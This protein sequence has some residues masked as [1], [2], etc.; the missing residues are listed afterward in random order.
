MRKQYTQS[1]ISHLLEQTISN[2][3]MTRFFK[4][5]KFLY[6]WENNTP[7]VRYH[8]CWINNNIQYHRILNLLSLY[9]HE[10]TIHREY[11]ITFAI[12]NFKMMA[13][14]FTRFLSLWSQ[15][16]KTINQD[17]DI[18]NNIQ[19]QDD[20]IFKSFKSLSAWENNTPIVR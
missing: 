14:V 5:F 6:T 10:E 1:T 19:Y 17:H 2:I 3:K 8:I 13:M 18:N 16:G 11:D 20:K 15:Y 7:R 4:S 9:L 12:S